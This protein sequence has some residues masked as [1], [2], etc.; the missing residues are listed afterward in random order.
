MKLE[1]GGE[2]VVVVTDVDY[3]NSVVLSKA[4]AFPRHGS[5]K[6]FLLPVTESL[7][8]ENVKHVEFRLR[9]MLDMQRDS[10]WY[11]APRHTSK[12]SERSM[13]RQCNPAN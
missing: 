1:I 5:D 12:L 10:Y 6:K 9:G 8:R 13:P 7:I 4:T 2:T 3:I 11:A